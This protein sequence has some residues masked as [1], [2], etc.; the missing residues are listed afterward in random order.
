MMRDFNIFCTTKTNHR[1]ILEQLKQLAMTNNTSGA[2]IFDLG[3]II[4]S[5]SIAEVSNILKGAE[6]KQDSQRQQEM[7]QQQQMQEQQLQAQEKEK[8]AE[9]EFQKAENEAE[10]KKDLMVAEI[11]AAG[12]G[13]QTDINQNEQSDF[14]DAMKDMQQRDEYREQMSFKREES[15]R[16]AGVQE[17]KMDIERERLTTQR[18]I[19]NTNLQIARENKNKYD[20][21]AKK[22]DKKDKGKEKK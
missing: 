8:A 11:R 4:K 1:S 17:S 10:R 14:K 9:R 16:N 5:D 18:D 15:A 13:A 7:Q 6:Q 3:S 21:A 22:E 19:A 12:Y 2:S 20:V